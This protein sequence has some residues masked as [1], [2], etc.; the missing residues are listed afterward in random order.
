MIDYKSKLEDTLKLIETIYFHRNERDFSYELYHNLRG[1]EIKVDLTAETPKRGYSIPK[2]LLE[3][4]FFHKH[5]FTKENY[6]FATAKFKKTPD[7]LF[8]E[9]QNRN[10]QLIAIEIKPLS[11]SDN[12]ILTDIA[13][14]M[15][16]TKGPLNYEN[17]TKIN[18]L[19]I[20]C[21]KILIDYSAIEI[22]IVYP[23]RVHK[24]WINND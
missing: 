21:S 22:W 1:M 6:D 9:Y 16:Y 7:L 11:K 4:I 14:L 24:N 2:I 18:R 8:H 23:N 15:F 17:K 13:K 19:K 20:K 10:H 5:F 12:L 3:N